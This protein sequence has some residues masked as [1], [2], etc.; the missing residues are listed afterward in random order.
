L[1]FR[2]SFAEKKSGKKRKR[3]HGIRSAQIIARSLEIQV[4]AFASKTEFYA[5]SA[6]FVN[7]AN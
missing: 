7:F 6:Q 1:F 2:F 5:H 4:V 3:P